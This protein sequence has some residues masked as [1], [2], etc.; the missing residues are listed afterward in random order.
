MAGHH[1]GAAPKNGGLESLMPPFSV[2]S[3]NIV[4]PVEAF[5]TGVTSGGP[6][7][8]ARGYNKAPGESTFPIKGTVKARSNP[9]SAFGLSGGKD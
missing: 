3:G 9:L 4:T 7:P 2:T 8:S 1:R 5:S 6:S